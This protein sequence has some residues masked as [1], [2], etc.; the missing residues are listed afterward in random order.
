MRANLTKLNSIVS[1]QQDSLT[2]LFMF[3][4]R[5]DETPSDLDDP[6]TYLG[7][8][9]THTKIIWWTKILKTFKLLQF[10][11]HTSVL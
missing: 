8:L 3:D 4:F 6:S 5:Q 10:S 9:A 2:L 7:V 1:L 11:A